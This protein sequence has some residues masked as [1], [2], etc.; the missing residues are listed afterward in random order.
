MEDG[1]T[2]WTWRGLDVRLPIPGR[3]NVRN[4]LLALGIGMEL[5]ITPEELRASEK[6]GP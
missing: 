1:S 2:V 5:G 3:F 6:Y 4:A